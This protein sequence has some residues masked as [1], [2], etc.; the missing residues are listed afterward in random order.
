MGCVKG[1]R[2]RRGW[3]QK[4][5]ELVKIQIRLQKELV[6]TG[7][8]FAQKY[9]Q[10]YSIFN[11]IVNYTLSSGFSGS[12]L[13]PIGGMSLFPIWPFK[14]DVTYSMIS[15]NTGGIRKSNKR[16][17]VINYCKTMDTDFFTLETHV[18]FSHL[19]DIR[20]LWDREVIILPVKTQNYGVLVLA[21]RT[22]P[23]IK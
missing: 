7:T 21:K 5:E 3:C 6:D 17:L 14:M 10:L 16:D 22:A 18:N 9:F 19:H 15:V 4:E 1:E 12:G 20:Q 23:P 13:I 8:L 2:E 11:D